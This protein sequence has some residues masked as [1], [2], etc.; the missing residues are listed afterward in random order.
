[1]PTAEALE[2]FPKSKVAKAT[3][4]G[5]LAEVW[6][7]PEKYETTDI[8][9]D[10][11]IRAGFECSKEFI[12][13][14]SWRVMERQGRELGRAIA[15]VETE[16]IYALYTAIAAADLASGAVNNGAGTL[17]WAGFV[18]FWKLIQKENFHAN[19]LALNAEQ[20]AD[21]W[22]QNEFIQSFYFGSQAD[23]RRGVLGDSYL[24]IKII[25]STKC[26]DGTVLAVDTDVAAVMLIRRDIAV[27]AWENPKDN[28]YGLVASERVGMGVLRSK[29]VARGTGW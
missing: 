16:K 14:A 26:T 6:I 9:V 22:V 19:V 24:G 28:K 27:E 4:G 29:G 15:E 13:D 7:L 21:L 18:S 2:R 5:Q 12:E 20:V 8:T 10:T 25:S 11:V 17:T 23:V 3:V 1:M